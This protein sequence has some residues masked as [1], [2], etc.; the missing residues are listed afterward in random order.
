MI[1]DEGKKNVTTRLL[2]K[3]HILQVL[4]CQCY[5]NKMPKERQIQQQQK[6]NSHSVLETGKFKIKDCG[7]IPSDKTSLPGLQESVF[8]LCVYIVIPISLC[9]SKRRGVAGEEDRRNRNRKKGEGR[10]EV[11]KSPVLSELSSILVKLQTLSPNAVTL[12]YRELG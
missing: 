3:N 4:V 12:E 10:K 7:D 6:R 11:L 2:G 1:I 9:L 8:F 5:N